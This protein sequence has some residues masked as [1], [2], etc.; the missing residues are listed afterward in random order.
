MAETVFAPATAPGRAGIAVIRL[1][2]PA[3]W[4]AVRRLT[5]QP[6][7]P[8]RRAALRLLRDAAGGALDEALVLLFAPG[9][10]FTGEEAAELHLH[11]APAAVAGV[12]AALAA[13]PGLRPAE[14]GEF[15]RRAFAA[16]RLDLTQVEGL[17]DL[18]AAET[19][20][21]RRRA[22]AGLRGGL[23]RAAA[24][25]RATLV[26]ARA[27]VEAEIDFAEEGVA[28]DRDAIRALV[29]P[30]RAELAREIGGAAAAER[31]REGFEV[32]LA[33]RPNAGKSSLLNAIAGREVALATEHAGTTRDVIE[34][35]LDLG[36]LPVTLLDMAGLRD[37]DD[38]VER[39]GVARARERAEAA[40]LRVILLA[41]GE[42]LAGLGLAPGPED[43]LVA[44]KA[45]LPGRAE[46]LPVSARTG[47]GI[48]ALLA[49]I[50]D[51]L[52]A[53][54]AP[55]GLVAGA[56]QRAALSRALAALERAEALLGGAA[57]A[58]E[59]VAEE[60]RAAGQALE[61]LLGRVDAE[62][63]LGEIFARFCIGK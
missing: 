19:A 20:A 22:L 30:L 37:S 61:A 10:G 62:E 24:G 33:G 52:S 40:D 36:G 31:I 54:A 17:A 47:E 49:R 53:R 42:D 13:M 11:G 59:L 23:S 26:S 32:A 50:R 29:A 9:S 1:S 46:G 63:I 39:L 7:P 12:L 34:L 55:A 56:R 45:D 5:G 14:P 48:A 18:I 21:Q 4:E 16:G 25:W 41:P 44:A 8:P 3:S 57:A 28:Q 27:L 51:I 6:L 58:P 35:R 60:L 15:T 43:I 38:P 2:G